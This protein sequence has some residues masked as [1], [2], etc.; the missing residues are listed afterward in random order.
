[1]HDLKMKVRNKAKVEGSIAE[2]YIMEEIS[3]F[4]SMYFEADIQTCRTQ[5]PR[6][7]DKGESVCSDRLSIFNHPGRAFGRSSTRMLDDRELCAAEIYILLNYAKLECYV[8]Q[9]DSELI[10]RNPHLTDYE[11]EK[12][13]EKSLALWLRKR[14]EQGLITDERVRQ[15]AY[16]P[17]KIAQNY[18]G[19]IMI[20]YR[21]HTKDYGQSK[22]T[23][24]SGICVKGSTYNES[25]YDYYGIVEEILQLQYPGQ[26][27]HIFLFKCHWFDLNSIRNDT[28]H[29]IVELKHKSKLNAYEPFILATQAQ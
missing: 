11:V 29:G 24:N 14:V 7:D 10:Q 13:R 19:F 2:T 17:S 6:N 4:C 9:F 26:D 22:S 15:I 21:F 27:N 28:T 25:E 12:E 3:N 16:D 1:M 20:V 5:P 18:P 8:E 23:M